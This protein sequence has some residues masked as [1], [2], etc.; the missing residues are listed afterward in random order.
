[1]IIGLT[2]PLGSGK[3]TVGDF[4]SELA[5]DHDVDVIRFSL[6]DEIR[7]ELERR[8]VAPERSKLKQIADMFRARLGSGVW[9]TLTASRIKDQI[10]GLENEDLLF[11]VDGIRNPGEVN[12][13]RSQ[14]GN[15]FKLIGITASSEKISRFLQLR[16]RADEPQ[17]ILMDDNKLQKLIESEMGAAHLRDFGHNVAGCLEMADFPVIR[18]D[19]TIAE[20]HDK[21]HSLAEQH[22]FPW[23]AD[24]V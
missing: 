2:G 7:N 5:Q 15:R 23:F 24:G 17:Q 14:F 18:N 19:E 20:L 3:G 9:A 12:E 6:S 8:G 16:N 11:I 22:I 13:F 10:D 4:L 1:M 21:V